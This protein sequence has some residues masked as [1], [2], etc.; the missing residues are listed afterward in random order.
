MQ[1]RDL[2]FE[3]LSPAEARERFAKQWTHLDVRTVEEFEEGHVEG[4]YNVPLFLQDPQYGRRPNPAFLE[5]VRASF[6]KDTRLVLSCA[7]A[8]RSVAACGVLIE[9]GFQSVANM[10]GGYLGRGDS[11]G[12]VLV[13][14][15]LA[16]GFAVTTEHR[17]GR[18]WATLSAAEG[19]SRGE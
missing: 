4:A 15:W 13:T 6:P 7:H 18:D 14:G 8:H 1:D 11:F 10:D 16:E 9:D 3:N 12:R 17:P 2:P 19:Q 5:V